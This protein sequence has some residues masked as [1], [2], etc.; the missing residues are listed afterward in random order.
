MLDIDSIIADS[1]A[2]TLIAILAVFIPK[3][4]LSELSEF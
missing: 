1:I 3:I 4:E 2:A